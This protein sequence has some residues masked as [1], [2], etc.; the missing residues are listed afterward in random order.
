MLFQKIIATAIELL[1]TGQSVIETLNSYHTLTIT[2]TEVET[3]F[4]Q[5]LPHFRK[6]SEKHYS[7]LLSSVY[8]TMLTGYMPD[9]TCLVTPIFR[10]YEFYLHRILGDLMELD[11]ETDK[12]TNNFA[13]FSK[14][15]SGMYECNNRN[16]GKLNAN[17]LDFL[18][19]LYTQ[20]NRV[21]HPYSHWSADD[22]DT[23]TIDNIVKARELL[24]KGLKLINEYYILF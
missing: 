11:T 2:K 23:A 14:N 12:G 7:N 6:E 4:D 8:N 19:R 21:R 16:T 13:F 24:E 5:L 9:Y 18:N 17:Q 10:A 1:T 15:S 3:K 20:Y 22:Y